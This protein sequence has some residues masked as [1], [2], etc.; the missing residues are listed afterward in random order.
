MRYALWCLKLMRLRIAYALREPYDIDANHA[1][2]T[3]MRR[4]YLRRPT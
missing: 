3:E 1:L 4:H 2:V